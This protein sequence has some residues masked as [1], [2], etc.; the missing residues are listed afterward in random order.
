MLILW[1]LS[2]LN[3]SEIKR[4]LLFAILSIFIFTSCDERIIVTPSTTII[5]PPVSKTDLI[6]RK[7]FITQIYYNIDGKQTQVAGTGTSATIAAIVFSSPNNYFT[8]SK[9]GKLEVYAEDKKGVKSTV[10]GTWKFLN[11]EKQV[12]LLYGTYDYRLDITSLNDKEAEVITPK[13]LMANLGSDTDTNKQIVLG[14]A[15]AGLIDNK[16]KEVKYGMKFGMK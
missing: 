2:P 12:Q 11:D 6:S 15:F 4:N 3:Y 9:D 13:I 5:T 8:F 14:G 1:K 16:T 7:W 10:I